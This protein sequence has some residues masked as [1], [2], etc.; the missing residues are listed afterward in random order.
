M[1]SS[2]FGIVGFSWA[3][4]PACTE[5]ETIIMNWLGQM[6]GLPE[7]LLPYKQA[8]PSIKPST[9]SSSLSSSSDGGDLNNNSD[10]CSGED[11]PPLAT[12]NYSLLYKNSA[13]RSG[14]VLLVS[15][16]VCEITLEIFTTVDKK[17]QKTKRKNKKGSA[18]ECVL[19]S[20]L[21]AR[22]RAIDKYKQTVNGNEEDGVILS[23][24][25]AYTSRIVSA[26]PL[27]IS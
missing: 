27:Y 26:A 9:S 18:S 16:V 2:G 19:V 3:S 10:A 6:S 5:L 1:L 23:K 11:I 12:N 13:P 15:C 17:K 21:S 24:L 20:M 8:A 25:V 22:C 7:S 4:S 14:G